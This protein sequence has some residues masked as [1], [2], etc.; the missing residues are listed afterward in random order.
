[1]KKVLYIFGSIL[2]MGTLGF[3]Y[4]AISPL[5]INIKVDEALPSTE[6]VK[7]QGKQTQEVPQSAAKAEV[8]GTTGHP[9]SGTARVVETEGKT[10]IRYED[11]KTINGPD[12]Y[13][14]LAKDLDAKEFVDLGRVRAT[15]G[16]INYEVPPGVDASDYRYVLTWCKQFGV[17][18]N[19]ADLG[20]L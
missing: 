3:A 1:M 20:I 13:V 16:N 17:L 8:V 9:A 15:E 4:Y 6:T 12:I 10:Y 5:F 2:L 7:T 18:F 11:F 19:Y 14:Y